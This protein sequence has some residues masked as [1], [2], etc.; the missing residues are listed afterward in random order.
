MKSWRIERAVPEHIP[1]IAANMREAD[2]RE[3]W[4]WRR[5]T[6]EAA[7]RFSLS[8][9]LAAWTGVIDER[10]ALM[11]GAGAASLLSSVGNPWLLGTD[12]ILS[13]QRPFLLHSGAFVAHMQAMFPRLENHVHAGNV[14]SI[15][16]LKWC[17]FTIDDAP[18]EFNGEDF[19]MFWRGADA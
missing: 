4:A 9:S 14:L 13:V 2:R 10:P 8:R 16:W 19:F 15:R 7:L 5:E 12:A 18:E 3:V 17:G 11:W 1:A 6:P